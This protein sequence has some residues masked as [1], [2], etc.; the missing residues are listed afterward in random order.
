MRDDLR[1]ALT[2]RLEGEPFLTDRAENAEDCPSGDAE[3]IG[4]LVDGVPARR[5]TAEHRDDERHERTTAVT[6]SAS[7]S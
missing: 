6:S 7:R 4:Q 2:L 5:E 3:V 1:L